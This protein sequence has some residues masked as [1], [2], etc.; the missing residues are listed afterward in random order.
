MHKE[1]YIGNVPG[2]EPDVMQQKIYLFFENKKTLRLYL[3]NEDGTN[4]GRRTLFSKKTPSGYSKFCIGLKSNCG[5]EGSK[6]RN[7]RDVTLVISPNRVFIKSLSLK[8]KPC[9]L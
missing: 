4:L 6:C 2:K 3:W 9:I 1:E 8:E 5:K 7:Q